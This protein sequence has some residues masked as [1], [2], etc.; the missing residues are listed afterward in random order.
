MTSDSEKQPHPS[1]PQPTPVSEQTP[2][3]T[4]QKISITTTPTLGQDKQPSRELDRV[5][6][7]AIATPLKPRNPT[8]GPV[9]EGE[10]TK[11][12]TN[13]IKA[14]EPTVPTGRAAPRGADYPDYKSS[15]A[16]IASGTHGLQSVKTSDTNSHRDSDRE[17]IV[18]TP[19]KPS[20]QGLPRHSTVTS[21]TIDPNSAPSAELPKTASKRTAVDQAVTSKNA[22]HSEQT[23]SDDAFTRL[24]S[25]VPDLRD[26][27]E[28]TDYYNVEARNR[29]LDR[30]RRAKA[31]AAERLR[32]EEE[33]RKLME[34][35]E[36][37]MG[38]QRSTVSRLTSAVPGA[39][40]GSGSN[41]LPTPV[42]PMVPSMG[43]IKD[44]PN[45]NAAK[46]AYDDDS[47]EVR[48]EKVPRLEAPPRPTET[49]RKSLE[50]EQRDA[51][52]ARDSR[53][54]S[55]PHRRAPSPRQSSRRSPPSR[56]RYHADYD[57]Y[58]SRSSRKSDRYREYDDYHHSSERRVSYPVRVDLGRKGG[59]YPSCLPLPMAFCSPASVEV[60][61]V[62]SF[63]R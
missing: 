51:R 14:T 18:P 6:V 61:C 28:M 24:L 25:Q 33:E 58:E 13:D 41:N 53:R 52:D 60:P 23:S 7:P 4:S 45:V 3:Q 11:A 56:P 12:A 47:I 16:S 44:T 46:R 48:Q 42:T 22:G 27:L 30:F 5:V 26:F 19:T 50:H 54:G 15:V 1:T 8:N 35:E 37:E 36:L 63:S 2:S 49:G 9:G 10:N 62:F 59:Q 31:L 40:A 21:S 20:L 34:E 29:K 39:P 32:I 57:D 43:E 55:S 38:L 17:W